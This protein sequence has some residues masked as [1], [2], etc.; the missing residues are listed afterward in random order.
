MGAGEAS[1]PAT[2]VSLI[3]GEQD[4]VLVDAVLTPE[5]AGRV[6]DWIRATRKKAL[7][8]DPWVL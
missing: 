8:T 2:A 7:L 6:V 4:A 1:W 3:S 5:D